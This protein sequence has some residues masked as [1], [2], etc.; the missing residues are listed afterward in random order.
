MQRLGGIVA[1]LVGVSATC[2][3]YL[4]LPLGSLS[5]PGPGLWPLVV[6]VVILLAS[7]ALLIVEGQGANYE[8]FTAR[9]RLVVLGLISLGLFVI[10]LEW[11]GFT[12][13]AFL[14]FVF[15]LKA[16]GGESWRLTLIVAVLSAAVL[17]VLFIN[18]LGV[19]LPRIVFQFQ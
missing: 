3:S 10:L 12:V 2:Y 8:R 14:T 13:P 7:L 15:W 18:L 4:V 19:P 11:I 1:L 5:N 17:H 9:T 16:L 6:S